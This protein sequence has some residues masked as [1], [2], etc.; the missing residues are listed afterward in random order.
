MGLDAI[1]QG[2]GCVLGKD[3]LKT[4]MNKKLGVGGGEKKK[5]KLKE[6]ERK[7]EKQRRKKDKEIHRR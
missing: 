5:K 3:H 7:G 4:E 1:W 2:E 6:K